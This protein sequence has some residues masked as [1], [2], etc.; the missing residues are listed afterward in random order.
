MND[1]TVQEF[2]TPAV[3]LGVTAASIKKLAT[4]YPIDQV[5]DVTSKDGMMACKSALREISGARIG[6]ENKRK[7]LVAGAVDW[8]RKI[9]TQAKDFKET[10]VAIET[11]YREA[12]VAEDE[13]VSRE[14]REAEEKEQGR[15]DGIEN[16]ISEIE[17]LTSGLLGASLETLVARK[18]EADAIG[19]L[20]WPEKPKPMLSR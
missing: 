1:V 2:K 3:K 12:K 11:P 13:R 14:K 9:N 16:K 17:A 6:L 4:K 19:R 15:M 18:A 10:I 7:E 20:W 5:P 8:Q